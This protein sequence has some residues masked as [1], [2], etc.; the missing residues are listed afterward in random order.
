MLDVPST[1]EAQPDGPPWQLLPLQRDSPV[2][3]AE[4]RVRTTARGSE[5]V[6]E[7]GLDLNYF[8]YTGADLLATP[9]PVPDDVPVVASQA[10][11]DA[12][13]AG[14]GEQV[15]AIV[16]D[17]VLTLRIARV[18]PT[19]PSAAG[20]L[21]VLAD[22]DALSRALID[23]GQLDP[24]VDAWW[25]G[26]PTAATVRELRSLDLGEVTLRTEVADQLA[27]GPLRAAVPTTL[28]IL[29]VLAVALALAA[30]ALVLGGER[31][32]RSTEVV[33]LRAL[34]LSRR[35]ARRVLVAEHVSFFVPVVLVGVLVGVV[36]VLLLGP[37]LVRSDLGAAPVPPAVVV[38][39]WTAEVLLVGG[40]VLATVVGTV[41]HTAA[42]VRRSDPARLRTG[43][44]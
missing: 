22:V 29:V 3:G 37:H 16:G 27:H 8:S 10:L 19:V 40:L 28:L 23:G 44:R 35:E 33:R 31:Q 5:L 15:S 32:R 7:L 14:V 9:F 21:A 11:V 6:S 24:V 26:R 38:W 42:H 25:V 43:V 18:V 12:A 36:S 2:K 13:G 41:L 17:S 4:A 30:V 39:P 34:G 1:D 20:Q